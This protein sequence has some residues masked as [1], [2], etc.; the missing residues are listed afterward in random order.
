MAKIRRS[1]KKTKGIP[2]S[3]NEVTNNLIDNKVLK[4]DIKPLDKP[5][6]TKPTSAP[7]VPLNFRVPPDFKVRMKSFASQRGMFMVDLL[8]EM[9]NEYES[10]H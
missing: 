2:P 4:Q 6:I 7:K 5:I 1:P 9:F 10:K 8:V 3:E